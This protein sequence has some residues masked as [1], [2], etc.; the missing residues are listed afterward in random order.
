MKKPEITVGD[1]VVRF[2][3]TNTTPFGSGIVEKRSENFA[4]VAYPTAFGRFKRKWETV[5]DI[6]R[7]A[8]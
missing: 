3:W 4:L 5:D 2:T 1:E 7:I 6:E 8:P